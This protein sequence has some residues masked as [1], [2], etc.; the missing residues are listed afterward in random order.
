M[1][2]AIAVLFVLPWLD[3]SKV[4]SMR[5]RPISKQFFWI[6]FVV[7][8]VLGW[9]GGQLPDTWS[10]RRPATP[11]LHRSRICSRILTAYYFFFFLVLMPFLG[12][13][14]KPLPVPETI[15]EPVLRSN[16]RGEGLSARI[17]TERK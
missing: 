5:Y 8:L 9:C 16:R 14:E 3:T 11:G 12:L 6:I 1:F 4:R 2:G 17:E 7:C 13:L 15:S 10:S